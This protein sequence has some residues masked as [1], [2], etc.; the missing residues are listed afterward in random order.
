[1]NMNFEERYNIHD[2]VYLEC[3]K[4]LI[5]HD[6]VLMMDKFIQHGKTTTLDHC[7]SVSYNSYKLAKLIGL[8]YKSVAR[9]GLLH[10]MFLYD[11]HNLP[12]VNSLFKMHGFT[13]ARIAKE[14]AM[15]YFDLLEVEID[16]I[17]RHMWPLNLTK[18][19]RYRE[20][21]LVSL[22]DKYV[23]TQETLAS[24]VH[25]MVQSI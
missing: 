18:P 13:H 17:E 1:M 24:H 23:S 14:N 7:V 25:K 19:P 3:I 22:V 21:L 9:G 2:E 8:D 5:S 11:W 16:I 10:D 15:K 12:K 4:D 20:S 6:A